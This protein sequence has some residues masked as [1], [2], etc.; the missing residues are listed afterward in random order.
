MHTLSLT[1]SVFAFSAY[2]QGPVQFLKKR[3]EGRKK[4][5]KEEI[6]KEN[7]TEGK[8][9]TRA[10]SFL[11]QKHFQSLWL[12]FFDLLTINSQIK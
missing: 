4:K 9:F 2:Y 8:E 6:R 3:E 1:A 11:C 5:R 7:F 10:K 12:R